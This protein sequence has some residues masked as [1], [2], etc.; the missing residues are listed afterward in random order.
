MRKTLQTLALI[1]VIG[2]TCWWALAG[3]NAGWTKTQVPRRVPDPVTG[4]EGVVYERQFVPGLDFLTLA[5]LTGIA[6][7]TVAMFAKRNPKPPHS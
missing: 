3:M 1:V 4:L 6:L 5:D 7:W 2:S